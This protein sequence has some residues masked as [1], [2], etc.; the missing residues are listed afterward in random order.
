MFVMEVMVQAVVTRDGNGFEVVF[1]V[2]L[3]W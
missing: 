2:I 3:W 1:D